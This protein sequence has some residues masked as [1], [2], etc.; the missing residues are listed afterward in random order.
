ME[1][2]DLGVSYTFANNDYDDVVL[3]RTEDTGHEFYTDFMWRILRTIS[4]RGFAGYE[5][6]EADSNHYN[7]RTAFGTPP[8]AADPTFEDGN[9]DSFLW[10]QVVEEDFWTVGLATDIALL[11]DR[12]NLTFAIQYQESDG[13]TNFDSQ[14]PALEDIDEHEDYYI[15]TFEAKA[16]YIFNDAWKFKVGYVYEK[17][18]YDDLQYLGYE[19][20]PGG[21]RLSGAYS[22]H[23]Y[24]AHLG[25]MTVVYSF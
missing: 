12:L 22:D 15:T 3:G 18:E 19:Y 17:G 7:Y 13:E 10:N 1:A 5:N 23:D 4:L 24:D 25:Y 8:Q 14:G 20:T 11:R 6:Y 21:T 16:N 2:L 9:P